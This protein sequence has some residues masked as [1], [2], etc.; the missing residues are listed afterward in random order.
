MLAGFDPV[1][2]K[3]SSCQPHFSSSTRGPSMA[4]S[5]SIAQSFPSKVNTANYHFRGARN[6][7]SLSGTI[8]QLVLK[9]SCGCAM[10]ARFMTVGFLISISYYGWMYHQHSIAGFAAFWHGFVLVFIMSGLGKVTGLL[11]R[12]RVLNEL[13]SAHQNT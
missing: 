7:I 10:S 12:R 11:L 4:S 1:P 13:R 6:R 5:R 9:D 2:G 8:R 3:I